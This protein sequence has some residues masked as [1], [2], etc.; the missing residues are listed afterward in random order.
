MN[1]A[2]HIKVPSTSLSGKNYDV[3]LTD[4]GWRCSCPHFIFR[5]KDCKH[6][7]IARHAHEAKKVRNVI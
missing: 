1:Q 4:K 7:Q 3:F 2:I 5:E 6:I